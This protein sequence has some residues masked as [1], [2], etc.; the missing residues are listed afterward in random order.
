MVTEI[1]IF[2]AKKKRPDEDHRAA[3]IFRQQAQPLGR[4]EAHERQNV[5]SGAPFQ[6]L[7]CVVFQEPVK[8]T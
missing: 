8:V 3:S 6:I 4:E 7:M 5:R 2:E 1:L